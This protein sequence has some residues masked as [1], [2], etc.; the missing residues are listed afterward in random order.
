MTLAH[1]DTPPTSAALQRL[2]LITGRAGAG[3]SS[4]IRVLE[5]LGY[6]T[7]D[8][9]PLSLISRLLDGPSAGSPLA[10]G[11]DTRNRDFSADT[12]LEVL[13]ELDERPG[14]AQEVLY[15]DC[16]DDILLRRYSE[17]RRRHPLAP[18]ESPTEGI[19]R[20]DEMLAPLKARAD[21]LIDTSEFSVHDLKAEITRLFELEASARLGISVHSFSYKMGLPRSLDFVFDCRFL[22]NPHWDENLRPLD[23]RAAEVVNYIAQDPRFGTYIQQIESLLRLVAPASIAEGKSHLSIGFGCTGGQ[24]RSVAL[25]ERVANALAEDGWRVSI[26]HREIERRAAAKQTTKGS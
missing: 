9:L 14:L 13:T 5:D 11:V 23:G 10:I 7:I 8:N 22:T 24:H 21:I 3:R 19:A 16:R 6:E 17:T 4:A 15:V 2:V 12:L 25:T 20:D 18:N 1:K 26:R